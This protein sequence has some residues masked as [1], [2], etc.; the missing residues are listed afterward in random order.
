MDDE[1][2]ADLINK[3]IEWNRD[4]GNTTTHALIGRLALR[5]GE[6]K[7][8]RDAYKSLLIRVR[9]AL[10]YDE[11]EDLEQMPGCAATT[12][13][14]NK[15]LERRN[16]MLWG[17]LED[18]EAKYDSLREDL[19]KILNGFDCTNP[20]KAKRELQDLERSIT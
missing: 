20:E 8:E 18:A 13:R 2:E 7:I 12:E 4:Q 10:G 15:M 1:S 6:L 14:G 11:N 3:V 5:V 16:K 9:E 17:R 19:Q